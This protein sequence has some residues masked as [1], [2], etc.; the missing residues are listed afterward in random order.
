LKKC[1]FSFCSTIEYLERELDLFASEKKTKNAIRNPQLKDLGMRDR[2]GNIMQSKLYNR[3][4]NYV[5]TRQRSLIA[6]MCIPEDWMAWFHSAEME[7]TRVNI[8]FSQLLSYAG[9]ED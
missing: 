7:T 8:S 5:Q 3:A 6:H 2:R 1:I 9:F 4:R